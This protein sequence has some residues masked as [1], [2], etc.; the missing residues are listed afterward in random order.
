MSPDPSDSGTPAPHDATVDNWQPCV[1]PV[2]CPKDG[3]AP[4]GDA[5]AQV[6]IDALPDVGKADGSDAPDLDGDGSTDAHDVTTDPIGPAIDADAA[7][8]DADADPDADAQADGDVFGDNNAPDV[9]DTFIDRATG[10]RE[11]EAGLCVAPHEPMSH[12]PQAVACPSARGAGDQST[13]QPADECM[14]D[15]ACTAGPNGRCLYP[16]GG[17]G[18]KI[19]NYDDCNTDADC[20]GNAVCYCRPSATSNLPNICL[21]GGNSRTDADCAS[22]VT[23]CSLSKIPGNFSTLDGGVVIGSPFANG[24]FC[25]TNTDCCTDDAECAPNGQHFDYCL[26]AKVSGNWTCGGG[27]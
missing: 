15:A 14:N 22:S 12:R 8:A 9:P 27:P 4:P 1:A 20:Q 17:P 11:G 13:P 7:H 26:Y 6:A 18:H 21:Y 24:Y 19:C 2:T 10:D 3:K 5:D 23:Y 16:V 25:H